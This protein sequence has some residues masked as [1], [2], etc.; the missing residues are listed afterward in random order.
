MLATDIEFSTLF[1]VILENGICIYAKG[2]IEDVGE[3]SGLLGANRRAHTNT[4][5]NTQPYSK[6]HIYTAISH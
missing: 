1:Q 4:Q 6:V 5:T 2:G 3:R